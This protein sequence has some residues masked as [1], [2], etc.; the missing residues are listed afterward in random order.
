MHNRH[1][2]AFPS[3]PSGLSL[4]GYVLQRGVYILIRWH[5]PKCYYCICTVCN[6]RACP[7]QRRQGGACCFCNEDKRGIRPR[8]ECDFFNHYLK[9]TR[10]RVHRIR[11]SQELVSLYNVYYKDIIFHDV[12]HEK[13]LFLLDHLSGARMSLSRTIVKKSNKKGYYYE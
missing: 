2:I 9:K 3:A 12:S 7:W 11:E 4:C 8:L 13:A 1:A 10:Y 6:S 5:H